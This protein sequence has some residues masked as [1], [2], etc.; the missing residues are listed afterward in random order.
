[1]SKY[2]A[3]TVWRSPNIHVTVGNSPW[4]PHNTG[5][6]VTTQMITITDQRANHSSNSLQAGRAAVANAPAAVCFGGLRPNQCWSLARQGV[7]GRRWDNWWKNLGQS[8]T[9]AQESWRGRSPEACGQE[10]GPASMIPC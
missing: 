9:E 3:I 10:L 2:R 6:K 4:H 1:M 7:W 8:G 5:I